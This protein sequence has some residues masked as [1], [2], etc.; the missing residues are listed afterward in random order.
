[1]SDFNAKMHQNSISAGAPLS[2]HSCIWGAY[3]GTEGEKREERE[4]KGGKEGEG[5]KKCEAFRAR[6]VA[7]PP[8]VQ[9]IIS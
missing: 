8:L 4:G 9:F 3:R 6:K 5:R 7:S 2:G 1:M